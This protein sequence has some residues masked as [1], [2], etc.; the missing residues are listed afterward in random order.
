MNRADIRVIQGGSGT[1]PHVGSARVLAGPLPSLPEGTS[2][3][4]DVQVDILCLID[5]SHAAAPE[6]LKNAV[7][8]DCTAQQGRPS[9]RI[10]C[11]QCEHC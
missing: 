3:R 8:G 9:M 2:A 11:L 5:N 10:V 1:P 7:M 6:P 4:H